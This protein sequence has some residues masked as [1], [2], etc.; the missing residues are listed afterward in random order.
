MSHIVWV[1][2][3]FS[4]LAIVLDNHA[5]DTQC[6]YLLALSFSWL[7]SAISPSL[8]YIMIN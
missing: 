5:V 3:S 8:F 2:M 6:G 7:Q 4:K 1:I